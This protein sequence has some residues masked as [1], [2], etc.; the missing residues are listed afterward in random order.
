MGGLILTVG[1]KTTC[2]HRMNYDFTGSVRHYIA[3]N[4]E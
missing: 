2:P 4:L 1:A 3:R